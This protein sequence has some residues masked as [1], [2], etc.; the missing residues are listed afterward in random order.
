MQS[1][2]FSHMFHSNDRWSITWAETAVRPWAFLLPL[3]IVTRKE[4]PK[5]D[6]ENMTSGVSF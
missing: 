5:Q 6:P 4:S 1:R 3:P 2:L